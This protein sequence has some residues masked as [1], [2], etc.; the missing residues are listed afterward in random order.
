MWVN[1]ALC[2]CGDAQPPAAG[3]GVCSAPSD[4]KG[5]VCFENRKLALLEAALITM[6]RQCI[7]RWTEKLNTLYTDK[8][9][10]FFSQ[11]Q[12]SNFEAIILSFALWSFQIKITSA[13]TF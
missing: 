1:R 10:T 7:F 9:V 13:F 3:E 11:F 8:I 5:N 2:R 4:E 6:N 12:I